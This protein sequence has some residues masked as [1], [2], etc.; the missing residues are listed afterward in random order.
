[1]ERRSDEVV[2]MAQEH[3]PCGARSGERGDPRPGLRA[4]PLSIYLTSLEPAI[5][6]LLGALGVGGWI[7][8]LT[9]VLVCVT[10]TYAL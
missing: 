1:M 2:R 9:L 5:L 6:C 3:Y 7:F 10:R 8:L 4:C